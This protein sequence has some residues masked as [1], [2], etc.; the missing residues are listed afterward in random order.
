MKFF[1]KSD[2]NNKQEIVPQ[3]IKTEFGKALIHANKK[4]VIKLIEKYNIDCKG[5]IDDKKNRPVLLDA[6]TVLNDYQD[7]ADQLEIITYLIE[8]GAD[9]DM[10]AK[11][12]YN[13]LHVSLNYHDLSNVTLLLIEKG[14]IDVNSQDD[15]GNNPIFIAIREYGKTWRPEQKTVNE[16]RFKI[17]EELLKK[18]ADL[19]LINNHGISSRRWLEISDDT[20]LHE[21]IKRY[22]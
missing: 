1:K 5:F 15:H 10:K 7:S 3:K 13:S 14:N 6:V 2:N 20:K 8:H 12:G 4:E 17:I 21:L 19:D 11:E 18:G 9:P 22:E 16:L